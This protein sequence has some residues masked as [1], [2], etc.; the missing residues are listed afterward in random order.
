[1]PPSPGAPCSFTVN[2]RTSV[3]FCTYTAPGVHRNGLAAAA[4]AAV[5]VP[6]TNTIDDA[7]SAVLTAPPISFLA[8]P[9][10]RLCRSDGRPSAVWSLRATRNPMTVSPFIASPLRV[11]TRKPP[12]P[13][14]TAERHSG[15][16]N[17]IRDKSSLP[18]PRHA[19]PPIPENSPRLFTPRRRGAPMT[20]YAPGPE[21]PTGASRSRLSDACAWSPWSRSTSPRGPARPSLR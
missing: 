7:T 20:R 5:S 15:M 19:A 13:Q 8:R 9:R 1:M 18:G 21:G 11:R 16:T 12:P 14:A 3:A 4:G 17:S 2:S 6:P 10:Q